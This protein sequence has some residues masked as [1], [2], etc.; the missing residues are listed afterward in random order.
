MKRPGGPLRRRGGD[1]ELDRQLGEGLQERPPGAP[2]E[3][4]V[5]DAEFTD[6]DERK[7]S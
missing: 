3:G 1:V 6:A 2:Q 4:D 7:A 5:I